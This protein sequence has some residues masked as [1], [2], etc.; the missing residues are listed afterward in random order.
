MSLR[1]ARGGRAISQWRVTE[2]LYN[3]WWNWRERAS[4]WWQEERGTITFVAGL[5]GEGKLVVAML[6]FFPP[7]YAMPA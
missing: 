1:D 7:Y 4:L 6:I 2:R 3:L 5:E